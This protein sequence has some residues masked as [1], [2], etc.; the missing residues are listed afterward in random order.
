MTALRIVLAGISGVFW[1]RA[2]AAADDWPHWRGAERD[3]R[4][5]GNSGWRRDREWP[6][7]EPLWRVNV[8]AGASSPVVA[9][10]RAYVTGWAGGQDTVRCLD[11][12][13]GKTLWERHYA[14]PEFGRHAVGDQGMYRGATATPEFD[15]AT[16]LLFTLGCD[17]SLRAWD[18][19]ASGAPVWSLNLYDRFAIPQ[20]PQITKRQGTRRDYGYTTA[21]FVWRDLVLVEAGDPERGCI[22]AFSAKTGGEPVWTS[23]NRDPAGH[24]GGMA[25]MTVDGV[26]CVAVATARNAL[27]VRLDEGRAGRT[28]AQFPWE[29]DF[30]NTIAAVA[31]HGQDLLISSRYNRMAMARVNVSLKGGAR[32]VW[33]NRHPTGVCTPVVH[34]GVIYFANHGVQCI[35]FATGRRLW[36]GGNFGDAGS[37]LVTADDRL[38]VWGNAGDLALVEGHG[39]SPSACRVLAERKGVFRDMAWP[40]VVAA[41]GCLL[42]KALNGDLACWTLGDGGP[43]GR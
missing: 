11:I 5:A 31:V 8:G 35:D 1:L 6:A 29:T 25:A 2:A 7:K 28:V 26:P 18:T 21:P 10:G 14:A 39:R 34:K 19:K 38:V 23:E 33:R 9:E 41:S 12:R 13:T 42:V 27:V 16:G 24:T 37:C 43:A 3:G 36:S 20:R 40:H 15:S 17:G 30:A 22:M 32:E 4:A